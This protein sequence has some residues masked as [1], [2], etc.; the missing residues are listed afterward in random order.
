MLAANGRMCVTFLSGSVVIVF[1]AAAAPTETGYDVW[2]H[3]ERQG[4]DTINNMVAI[5][6]FLGE[7]F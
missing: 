4:Q 1:L 6:L 7:N 2:I 3:N 5:V